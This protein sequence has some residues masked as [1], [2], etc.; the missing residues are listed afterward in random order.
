MMMLP[1]KKLIERRRFIR[2]PVKQG[3]FVVL[4]SDQATIGQLVDIG[5]GGLCY[6]YIDGLAM[7][8]DDFEID[9][10]MSQ[11]GIFLRKT[12]VKTVSDI[13]VDTH[14]ADNALSFGKRRLQFNELNLEQTTQLDY[15][16]QFHTHLAA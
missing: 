1:R 10:F 16:I 7:P 9:L 13:Q 4:K 14:I 11:V 3:A 12:T 8:G 15:F 6:S 2:F 5:R